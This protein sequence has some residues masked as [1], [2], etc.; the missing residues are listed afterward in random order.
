MNTENVRNFLTLLEKVVSEKSKET[1]IEETEEGPVLLYNVRSPFDERGEI[2]YQI[3]LVPED[4]DFSV[5]ELVMYVWAE[6]SD[7]N[8]TDVGMLLNEINLNIALGSYKFINGSGF[9]VFTQSIVLNDDPKL[10][11]AVGLIGNTLAEMERT[12]YR[13]AGYIARLLD[14]EKLASVIDSISIEPGL[15]MGGVWDNEF[16]EKFSRSFAEN[17]VNVDTRIDDDDGNG[18]LITFNEN[19]QIEDCVVT[20]EHPSDD[21]TE[22]C[23]LLTLFSGLERK[24]AEDLLT[25]L[26][27]L[28]KDLMFGCF[29]VSLDDGDFIFRYS[30]TVDEYEDD[31]EQWKMISGSFTTVVAET[32]ECAELVAPVINGSIPVSE[33]MKTDL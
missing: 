7:E 8:S 20:V 17:G 22:V 32:E 12:V 16:I 30:F 25:L 3:S 15:V 26:P 9:V 28:N 24:K 1:S 6:V 2:G 29:A 18:I 4:D 13:T 5:C 10:V 23:I 19:T 31:D 11:S 21:C 33:L 27:Y 14:G